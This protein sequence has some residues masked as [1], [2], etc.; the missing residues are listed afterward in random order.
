MNFLYKV[1]LFST[2]VFSLSACVEEKNFDASGSFEADE[3]I[4]SSEQN[5][6]LLSFN[7]QEGMDLKA[8][9]VVGQ[10]DTIDLALQKAQV[11]ATME[12]IT[13]KTVGTNP[14]AKVINTQIG[15]QEAQIETLRKQLQLLDIEVARVQNMFEGGA[16]TQKQLDDIKGQREILNKQL[17]TAQK[18][19]EV[20]NSQITSTQ[21]NIGIQN[22][23]ILAELKPTQ[24]KLD[25]IN[26]QIK[27]AEITNAVDGVVLTK[28][29]MQGEFVT[30]GK[31]LY[32]IA[33]LSDITLK[34]YITGDQLAKIALNQQVTVN[35]DDG[36][37]G[38][39]QHQGTVTWISSKAEFTPKTI[40][41][42]NERANLV[43]AI[44]VKVK[45]DGSLKIGMYGEI[46]F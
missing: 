8:N 14:Q 35:T 40:Q 24:A 30:I 11:L 31:P 23:A 5:G 10:I 41:T 43:Y 46:K 27:K 44:K 18:Q 21:E 9:T 20:L 16:A 38:F 13:G 19:V 42:K 6:K 12:A 36:N 29:V 2:F 25:L 28:Y 37:G 22:K 33:D 3:I 32:K 4:I 34:A 39:K 26:Q 45:N 17:E 15:T 7:V 1:G